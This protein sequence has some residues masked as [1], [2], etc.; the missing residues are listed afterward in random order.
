MEK[1]LKLLAHIV[2]IVT[3]SFAPFVFIMGFKG[4]SVQSA[5]YSIAAFIVVF[6]A[7]R[8]V[9]HRID[10]VLASPFRY[11]RFYHEFDVSGKREPRIEDFLDE[12]LISGGFAQIERHQRE[13]ERWKRDSL[14]L[15]DGSGSLR[16]YRMKQYEDALDDKRAFNFGFVRMQ[17]RYTQKNYVRTPHAV[18]V[19]VSSFSYAYGDIK[20]RYDELESIGFE[21]T[22]RAYHMKNQRRLATRAL[23]EK[24]MRRDNYTCQICGKHMPDEVGLQVDHIVPVSKGG[25]TVESNLRVL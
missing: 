14:A 19:Q 8:I 12:Y 10:D 24:I 23:R 11:P 15:I 13:V 9:T 25:K 17:T 7:S 6:V 16:N 5:M 4:A 3:V 21:C 1:V 20:S 2:N 18:S 22:L